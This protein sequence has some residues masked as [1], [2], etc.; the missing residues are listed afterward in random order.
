[1]LNRIK[2]HL[3]KIVSREASSTNFIKI[4]GVLKKHS[5]VL[6][7]NSR[8]TVGKSAK[9]IIDEN[10]VIDGCNIVLEKGTLIIGKN[11]FLEQGSNFM[12]PS[13][14]ISDGDL[15][16]GVN[17]IVRADFS[18]RFG[19]KCTIGNYTGIMERT[20]I[21]SDEQISIGDFNMISYECMIY[22]T[23][24]HSIYPKEKRREMTMRD[25]PLIGLEHEKPIS[26]KVMIGDDCW[27]GKRSVILKGVTIGNNSTIAACAVV[28]KNVSENSIAFGNPARSKLK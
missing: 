20:E 18:I 15:T 4:N 27:I 2:K 24:T 6:I 17:C 13:I 16:I 9:I 7:K 11:T 23:N 10:A 14:H 26:K 19:G 21:R 8:I 28:T 1:M 5:T 3:R 12:K 22:D 25:F